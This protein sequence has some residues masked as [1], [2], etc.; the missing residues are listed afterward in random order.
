[1]KKNNNDCHPGSYAS[2]T[3]KQLARERYYPGPRRATHGARHAWVPALGYRLARDDN[4][5]LIWG[6]E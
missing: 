5:L 1:M 2:P 3:A 4:H 6:D